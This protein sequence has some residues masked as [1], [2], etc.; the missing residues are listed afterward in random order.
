[1]ADPAVGFDAGIAYVVYGSATLADTLDLES[2]PADIT[3]LGEAASDNFGGAVAGGD[4]NG[5]GLGD[6]MVG[7]R[8]ADSGGLSNTGK[9][10]VIYGDSTI[11]VPDTLDASTADIVIIGA[12]KDD[13]LGNALAVGDLNG[14]TIGDLVVSAIWSD[15]GGTT[16]GEVYVFYGDPGDTTAA[17]VEIDLSDASPLPDS[18]YVDIL[19]GTAFD[20]T[21][22]SVAAGDFNGDGI[23]DIAIGASGA[24]PAGMS[25]AGE[26]HIMYGGSLPHEISL[27]GG[28]DVTIAGDAALASLGW[29]MASLNLNGDGF[30]DLPIGASTGDAP[31]GVRAGNTHVILGDPQ[32]V[33]QINLSSTAADITIY[34]DDPDDAN[35]Y[36][37]AAADMNGDFVEDMILGAPTADTVG[38]GADAGEVYIIYGEAP[39]VELSIP[40]T[41]ATYNENLVIPVSVD[42]TNGLKMAALDLH[43]AFDSDLLLWNSI[44]DA[45]TLINAWTVNA[46][47]T[48]GAATYDRYAESIGVDKRR[49]VHRH[50]RPPEHR[51]HR[52]RCAYS[53]YVDTGQ[54]SCAI[55]RGSSRMGAP[56][57]RVR[58]L[59]RQRRERGHNRGFDSQRYRACTS[60]RSRPQRRSG[61]D[62]SRHR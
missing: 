31:G 46:S 1:M 11:T 17:T 15:P 57:R 59:T 13:N 14:D 56:G 6:V 20:R 60:H 32:L 41:S 39:Y 26:V 19:G 23:D 45:G 44:L 49:S 29:S 35:S 22:Q 37:V 55:Q 2:E 18:D 40:D 5:D 9:T 16:S 25:G 54:R 50:G 10:Y 34:G 3:L 53:G 38:G 61:G 48:P 36:A 51:F 12:A 42:T 8:R 33:N 52:A 4:I 43:L 7:A 21:G 30:D 28:A 24:D 62:R 27:P 47:V 58:L